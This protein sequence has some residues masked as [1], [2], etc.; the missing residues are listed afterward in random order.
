MLNVGSNAVNHG[1]RDREEVSERFL[2]A[3]DHAGFD[4][5]TGVPC[6][7]LGR[8]WTRLEA[9]PSDRYV[10]A[11]REDSAIGMAVGAYLGGRTPCVLMQ[12]SGLGVSMNALSSLSLLYETPALL[13]VS[14]RGEGGTGGVPEGSTSPAGYVDAPEHWLMGDVTRRY[15]ELLGIP[16]RILEPETIE[17]QIEA[18]REETI[19]TRRPVAVLVRKGLMDVEH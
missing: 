11:V 3:L 12:N 7:L 4:F 6:S 5:F 8:L 9:L 1:H 2:R 18:L 16:H 19:R 13:V 17:S 10:C 15:F 14:W